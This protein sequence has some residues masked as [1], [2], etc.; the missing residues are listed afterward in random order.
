VVLVH[1]KEGGQRR[2]ELRGG[3]GIDLALPPKS[4]WLFDASTGERLR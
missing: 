2:L 1:S 3:R 4:S